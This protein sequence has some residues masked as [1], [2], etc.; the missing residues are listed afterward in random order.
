MSM[1]SLPGKS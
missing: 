1:C